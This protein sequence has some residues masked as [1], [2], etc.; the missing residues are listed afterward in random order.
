MSLLLFLDNMTHWGH[1][2]HQGA[3]CT[4]RHK[5]STHRWILAG[6]KTAWSGLYAGL[7][8]EGCIFLNRNYL[9]SMFSMKFIVLMYR[10]VWGPLGGQ[11]RPYQVPTS[12]SASLMY[13][14]PILLWGRNTFSVVII[15]GPYTFLCWRKSIKNHSSEVPDS[16]FYYLWWKTKSRGAVL[17]STEIGIEWP[18]NEKQ[19]GGKFP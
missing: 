9:N 5:R 6:H 8:L 14:P 10:R 13:P 16:V 17:V 19:M 4:H 15:S 18:M 1:I 7:G 12:S 2:S 11:R 3:I